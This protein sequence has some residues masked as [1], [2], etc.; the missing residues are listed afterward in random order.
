MNRNKGFSLVELMVVVAIIAILAT[1]AMP[2]YNDYVKKG[3][4]ASAKQYMMDVASKQQQYF[5]DARSYLA[6]PNALSIPTLQLSAPSDVSSF[7]TMAVTTTDGPPPTFTI[8]ATP[9]AGTV[10]ATDPVLTLDNRGVKT[11][12]SYW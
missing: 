3:H 1:I 6:A 11:P 10:Q 12:E 2:S 5:M 8:T 4:R 7:Y 9:K